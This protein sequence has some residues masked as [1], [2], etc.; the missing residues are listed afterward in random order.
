MGE[1]KIEPTGGGP[2]VRHRDRL[3][4]LPGCGRRAGAA[5][6]KHKVVFLPDQHITL[7]D[8]ERVTDDRR[9]HRKRPRGLTDGRWSSV[10]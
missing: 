8:L 4:R 3:T 5:A 9:A 1:P 7:D 2:C 6:V 10:C